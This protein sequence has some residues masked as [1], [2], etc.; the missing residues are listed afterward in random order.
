MTDPSESKVVALHPCADIVTGLRNIID[1]IERGDYEMGG[2]TCTIVMGTNVFHLGDIRND[3]GVTNAVWNLNM[4][5]HKLM[6]AA[7]GG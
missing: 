4:G 7:N 6:L 3:I 5:L 2:A 1:G